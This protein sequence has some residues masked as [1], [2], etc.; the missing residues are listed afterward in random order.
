MIAQQVREMTDEE[1]VGRLD[2]LYQE[3]L[4]LRFQQVSQQLANPH[5]VREVRRDIARIKTV[6][7]ERELNAEVQ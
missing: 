2:E 4:N 5:R 3:Q 1:L 7:R 6:M